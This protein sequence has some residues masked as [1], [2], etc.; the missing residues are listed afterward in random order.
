MAKITIDDIELEAADGAPVLEVCRQNGIYVSSLCYIDGLPPYAGCRMCL[1]EI[2]GARGLQL[3]CNS[4]VTDG[5][6]VRTRTTELKDTRR[7]VLSL[8]LSNHSDRC[9][10]CHRTEHCRPGDICLRDDVVTHRCITCSKNYRCELQTTCELVGMAEY[11]PWYTE[12]R[13]YYAVE[14]HRPA[15]RSN[16]F[17]EFDPQMCILCA[18]C[19]RA[20]SDIRYT[21][22]ITL[23]N[24]GFE[25]HIAFGADGPIHDSSCDFCGACVDVCPTATLMEH[26]HKWVAKPDRWT[27]TTCNSCSV[28]CNLQIGTQDGVGVIVKPG[29]SNP[30]SGNQVCVRGRFGYDAVPMEQYAKRATVRRGENTVPVTF[31]EAA[32]TA[33]ERL[34]QIVERD[35]ANAVGFLGSPRWTV[36]ENIALAKLAA[37]VGSTN[38]DY[39]N[40]DVAAAAAGAIASVFGNEAL[41]ASGAQLPSANV[42]LAVADDLEQTHNVAALRIK[43]AVMRRG[44]KLIVI[45]ATRGELDDFAVLSIRTA[46]GSEAVALEAIA[47]RLA[48]G[49]AEAPAFKDT[50]T[51]PA[52]LLDRAADLLAPKEGVSTSFVYA[53]RH[54]G[55]AEA[56]AAVT[57]LSDVAVLVAGNDAANRTIVFPHE[58]NSW[59]LR[60]A[61]VKPG[62]GGLDFAGMMAAARDGRLKALVVAGD[63]PMLFAADKEG[64][65][66]ALS[67]LELLVVADGLQ[68]ETA[69]LAHVFLPTGHQES[70]EGTSVAGDRYLGRVRPS[71]AQ[72]GDQQPAYG[73][74]AGLA[75]ALGAKLPATAAQAAGTLTAAIPG[76]KEAAFD[77]LGNGGRLQIAAGKGTLQPVPPVTAREKGEIIPLV[78][79]TLYTSYEAASIGLE[80]ADKLGRE[81]RVSV[82][83]RTASSLGVREGDEIALDGPLTLPVTVGIHEDVPD[84]AVL[85]PLHFAKGAGAAFAEAGGVRVKVATPA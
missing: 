36:E 1:V 80:D 28:G 45:G 49:N 65:R 37:A 57:A 33:I 83:S 75:N 42:I 3:A 2:E 52:A 50:D 64:T 61:G 51:I 41:P 5:M 13:S 70:H 44:G 22:A 29:E 38:L 15:D 8:I 78:L 25:A 58:A 48:K 20:C 11:E 56:A 46:P 19:V 43:D 76:Y 72:Q 53:M 21:S 79:R 69:A 74:I 60:D 17:I 40:G 73:V 55:A 18:R 59:G 47:S 84:G 14:Q 35:G 7:S 62:E 54:H 6:V 31:D 82:N 4:R 32:N 23:A 26:P 39:T 24:K 9:L 30:F 67:N 34:K 12:E 10:T 63:N 85:V 77:L 16:P 81:T 71:I 27:P 68:T 66:Q